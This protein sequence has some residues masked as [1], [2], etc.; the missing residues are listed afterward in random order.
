MAYRTPKV[1]QEEID[2]DELLPKSFFEDDDE[3][4]IA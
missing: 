3:G 2:E 1:I 4:D